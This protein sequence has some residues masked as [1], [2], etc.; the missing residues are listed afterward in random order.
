VLLRRSAYTLHLLRRLWAVDA[1]R[2]A[3]YWEQGAMLFLMSQRGKQPR[4]ER[5]VEEDRSH[6]WLLNRDGY[7]LNGYPEPFLVPERKYAY[8]AGDLLVHFA[9]CRYQSICPSWFDAMF[10]ESLCRNAFAGHSVG[11]EPGLAVGS[12]STASDSPR[13]VL[14]RDVDLAH[15]YALPPSGA[16]PAARQSTPLPPRPTTEFS[17]SARADSG[18]QQANPDTVPG[19]DAYL[20]SGGDLV[21]AIA[22]QAHRMLEAAAAGPRQAGG[23]SFSAFTASVAAT[24]RGF[25][26]AAAEVPDEANDVTDL[27]LFM[28]D[29]AAAAASETRPDSQRIT[30]PFTLRLSAATL[31]PAATGKTTHTDDEPAHDPGVGPTPAAGRGPGSDDTKKRKRKHGRTKWRPPSTTDGAAVT[32]QLRGPRG[33]YGAATPFELALAAVGYDDRTM[34]LT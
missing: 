18:D 15:K 26:R 8:A 28:Y 32:P 31:R 33:L 5:C 19:R 13:E 12:A 7:R 9:S 27:R 1:A 21:G 11:D 2:A 3:P 34:H 22:E 25:A 4:P 23:D 24:L 29:A 6:L 10:N 16:T 30:I 14:R 17:T 20:F